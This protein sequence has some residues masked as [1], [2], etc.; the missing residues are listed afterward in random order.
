MK[1]DVVIKKFKNETKMLGITRL[2][3]QVHYQSLLKIALIRLLSYVLAVYENSFLKHA[4]LMMFYVLIFDICS[5]VSVSIFV[6]LFQKSI[7]TKF[8]KVIVFESFNKLSKKALQPA[9]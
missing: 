4:Y 5:L 8:P 6:L 7:V 9:T 1:M 2:L 3:N